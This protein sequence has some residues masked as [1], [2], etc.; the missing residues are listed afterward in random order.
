[1]KKEAAA[2]ALTYGRDGDRLWALHLESAQVLLALTGLWRRQQGVYDGL[3][4]DRD[5]IDFNDLEHFCAKILENPEAAAEYRDRFTAII[6]DEYQDSNAVQEAILNRIR[7]PD[8]L[9]FV[10]DV[11]QSIYGFRMA[12]PGLFLEK[13][14]T[15]TGAAGSRIDLS[16]IGRAHV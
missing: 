2:Q 3:K 8:D 15:F 7:R 12:E 14:R 1:M 16:Q 11:K 6:V 5:R 10:G 9:F 13:L 4:R